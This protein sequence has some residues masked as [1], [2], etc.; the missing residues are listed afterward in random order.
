MREG[1]TLGMTIV[2]HDDNNDNERSYGSD[3][4]LTVRAKNTRIAYAA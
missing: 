1:N 4:I 2:M 3:I